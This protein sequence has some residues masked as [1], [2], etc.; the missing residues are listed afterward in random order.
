MEKLKYTE[1]NLSQCHIVHTPWKTTPYLLDKRLGGPQSCS[2]HC[3]EENNFFC[4]GH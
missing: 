4:A 2:R 1:E 3:A